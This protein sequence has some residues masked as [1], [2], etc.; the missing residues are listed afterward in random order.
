VPGEVIASVLV[1]QALEGC[2]DRGVPTTGMILVSQ[3]PRCHRR[4]V[5]RRRHRPTP[6]LWSPAEIARLL[7]EARALRSL[8][9]AATHE[10]LFGLLAATGS[11]WVRPSALTATTSTSAPHE[12][13]HRQTWPLPARRRP[14]RLPG[15]PNDCADF[16]TAIALPRNDSSTE[17]GITRMS[18]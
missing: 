9:R 14:H 12:A 8:L 1:L 4:A 7:D 16:R 3:P 17:V 5:P 11:G 13:A 10:A 2:S 15:K 6:Y 18:A